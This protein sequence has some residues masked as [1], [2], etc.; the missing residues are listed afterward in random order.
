MTSRLNNYKSLEKQFL[1]KATKR[2]KD[3]V[4][5]LLNLYKDGRILNKVTVQRELNRYLG[6]SFKNETE[7]DLYYYKTFSGHLAKSL[8]LKRQ[9]EKSNKLDEVLDKIDDRRADRL[10]KNENQTTSTKGAFSTIH[11]ELNTKPIFRNMPDEEEV[12][13]T[14]EEY[15][16]WQ[17]K[18]G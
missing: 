8:N 6:R 3:R 1:H 16:S 12:E 11:I 10:I 7:R 14:D 5:D 2:Q 17:E 4:S 13:I 15:Q 18:D 9:T